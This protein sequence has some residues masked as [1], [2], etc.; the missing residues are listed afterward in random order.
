MRWLFVLLFALAPAQGATA[1]AGDSDAGAARN[2]MAPI[3]AGGYRPLYGDG[4][5]VEVGAFELD[6]TPVTNR[7]FLAFLE[8]HPRWRRDRVAPLFAGEG[9]LRHWSGA[10]ELGEGAAAPRP[11]AP[12]IHVSWFAARAYCRAAGKRL[13]T[14]DEWEWVALADE[15][16]ADGTVD[17]NFHQRI[18]DWYAK[19]R[20]GP[21]PQVRS[22][23]RNV[24]GVYDMHGL[25]WEWVE[26]WGS[27]FVTGESRADGSFD[28]QLYCAAGAVGAQ[29]ARN[30]AAFLRYA[31][32]SGLEANYAVG[33][34]GFRCARSPK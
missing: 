6:A 12:V 10:L 33:N 27:V 8:T 31:M 18:L 3:A 24:Y 11:E 14:L 32:R 2:A 4:E 20:R 34:L 13:P 21:L 1:N 17:P 19:P 25:I 30:Y 29:D 5:P 22:T 15:T 9:Y 26:D 23:F 28:R 16:R 7:E